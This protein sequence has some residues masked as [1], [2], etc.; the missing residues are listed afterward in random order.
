MLTITGATH[1][2]Q[3][4]HN[5]D[6]FLVDSELG[7]GLVADGMGGYAC[8]EVASELVKKTVYES[9]LNN[10]QLSVGISA[11]HRLIKEESVIDAS[12]A[13]M[14]ST[15]VVV[16]F[17]EMDY[18]I[19]WVGDS[20]AYLWRPS[21]GELR[22]ISR[23]HSYVESLISSGVIS[24]KEAISHPDRNLITQAVGAAADEGLVIDVVSGR[25][26]CGQQL[27]LCSDGLVDEL[28]DI[29]IAQ[30]LAKAAT[31]AE[32]VND[33]VES[34]VEA[35]GRD[36]VTVVIASA[37]TDSGSETGETLIP[38][39]VNSTWL[40]KSYSEQHSKMKKPKPDET[41]AGIEKNDGNENESTIALKLKA[42]YQTLINILRPK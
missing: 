2:G 8:G 29:E 14:G 9:A 11:A 32:A 26:D 25:L 27:I 6:C 35:G 17:R 40:E 10:Q 39:S 1:K 3:R 15:V 37:S 7:F 21:A 4:Q 34:A 16:K 22:Q 12:K 42:A 28:V 38:E 31:P 33:L 24:K 19:A 5:E 23:D 30:L 20:R 36:N 18:T 13:G 41:I